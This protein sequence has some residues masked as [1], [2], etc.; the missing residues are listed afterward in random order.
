MDNVALTHYINAWRKKEDDRMKEEARK[1]AKEG[2]SY[3][4]LFPPAS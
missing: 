1:K 2:Q 4:D 3:K